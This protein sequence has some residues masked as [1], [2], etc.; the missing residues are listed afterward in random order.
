MFGA[1]YHGFAGVRGYQLT[2]SLRFRASASAY[3]S[4]TA[5]TPTSQQKGTISFWY[6]RGLVGSSDLVILYGN[7]NTTTGN[8]SYQIG[9][10]HV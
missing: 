5:G 1:K 8:G 3:L 7:R 10:A 6:K 9:R 4:R 2:R